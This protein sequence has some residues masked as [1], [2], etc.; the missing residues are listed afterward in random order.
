MLSDTPPVPKGHRTIIVVTVEST[1]MDFEQKD[2]HLHIVHSVNSLQTHAGTI[3]C[4]DT[5]LG[6][7][8]TPIPQVHL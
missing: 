8:G 7:H 1:M 2:P 4:Y 3:S 5:L 6:A